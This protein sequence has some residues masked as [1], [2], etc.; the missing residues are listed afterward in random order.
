MY[1]PKGLSE[2]DDTRVCVCV[3]A[4][5]DDYYGKIP[6]TSADVRIQICDGVTYSGEMSKIQIKGMCLGTKTSRIPNIFDE[7]LGLLS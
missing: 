5:A 1:V 6:Q 3:C 4:C 2:T 7:I